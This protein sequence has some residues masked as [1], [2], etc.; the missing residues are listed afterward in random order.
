MP[1]GSVPIEMADLAKELNSMLD[2]LQ[3][4]FQRL[5]DF[6]SDLAHE[7]R[8]PISNLMTQTQVVL[9]SQRDTETYRDTLASNVEEFQRLA[10]LNAALP[11]LKR[12]IFKRHQKSR[13]S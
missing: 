6:S 4:D 12:S 5:S 9:S 2:R 1:V 13:N 7:L 10:R 11:H 3:S 8:T